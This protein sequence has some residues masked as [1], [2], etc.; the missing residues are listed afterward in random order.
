[1]SL[2]ERLSDPK[3]LAKLTYGMAVFFAVVVTIAIIAYNASHKMY[4]EVGGNVKTAFET[5]GNVSPPLSTRLVFYYSIRDASAKPLIASE[6]V[7]IPL[8]RYWLLG[9]N[10]VDT[11]ASNV[12][13]TACNS[14]VALSGNTIVDTYT[15]NGKVILTKLV[16]PRDGSVIFHGDLR[17]LSLVTI[18]EITNVKILSPHRVKIG[19]HLPYISY[20][21]NVTLDFEKCSVTHYKVPYPEEALL[22][23]KSN[24][25][26]IMKVSKLEGKFLATT[27][28]GERGPYPSPFY[29][30]ILG[31]ILNGILSF[32]IIVLM[33]LIAIVMWYKVIKPNLD[34]FKGFLAFSITLVLLGSVT[35]L[36]WD[37]VMSYMFAMKAFNPVELYSWTRHMQIMVKLKIPSHYPLFPGYTYITPWI[38]IL[39][40][41]LSLLPRSSFPH[42]FLSVSSFDSFLLGSYDIW[43]FRVSYLL[44]YFVLGLW[45][46]LFNIITYF[47]SSKVIGKERTLLFLYSPF[48]A[49]VS[50]YWKMFEPMLL[51]L[52]TIILYIVF[53][54][55]GNY[56][57][58][59]L[60]GG[61]AAIVSTKVYPLFT[62]LP[63][64]KTVDKKKL[65]VAA[66][67]FA[68]F[69]TP[70]IVTI[71]ALGIKKFLFITLYYQSHREIAAANYFPI[72]INEPLT[73]V[74]IVG[75]IG[76]LLE[77][78]GFLLVFI[79]F[80]R[81]KERFDFKEYAAWSIAFLVPYYFFNKIVSPQNY[82]FFIY[83]LYAMGFSFVAS[84]LSLALTFYVMFVFPTL[85]YFAL[86]LLPYLHMIYIPGR[87]SILTY[88]FMTFIGMIRP[89]AWATLIPILFG[90]DALALALAFMSN[91]GLDGLKRREK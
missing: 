73:M 79:L 11:V 76:T 48:T 15:Y 68:V 84:G 18:Y 36:H 14:T 89:L 87:K 44:Y 32:L 39:L 25:T 91:K 35:A 66:L 56:L 1:M 62:L 51:A 75:N 55:K 24:R 43:R 28:Y 65:L 3:E 69:L 49:L 71:L 52:F 77:L 9:V 41:P 63:L 34:N 78:A 16:S 38:A 17:I 50:Y 58:Y 2:R 7:S 27:E 29:V 67:G 47:V 54:K 20:Y 61:L 64:V 12:S 88:I 13:L 80:L 74:K 33:P 90:F 37:A 46:M 81:K 45:Y 42:G 53:K 70:A 21:Y 82:L 72:V 19:A 57:E 60:G 59:F 5:V 85:F 31:W 10:D 83:L 22:Y 30:S 26:C 40:S 23:I 6:D 8:V 86:P 4:I